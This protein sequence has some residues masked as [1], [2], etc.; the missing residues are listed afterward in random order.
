MRVWEQSAAGEALGELE[1]SP[2][3]QREALDTLNFICER[4]CY[5]VVGCGPCIL[6]RGARH[7]R[8]RC[9]ELLYSAGKDCCQDMVHCKNVRPS[10]YRTL[11]IISRVRPALY[12][13]TVLQSGSLDAL[14]I[15]LERAIGEGRANGVRARSH[16]RT[17]RIDEVAEVADSVRK[18]DASD[19]TRAIC[20]ANLNA[21]G[22]LRLIDFE[23]RVH[24]L[25]LAS[26]CRSTGA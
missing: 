1:D 10:L 24:A 16:A 25:W 11:Q 3:P 21:R 18:I 5:S 7:T 12:H 23:T 22:R 20:E 19:D 9:C 17:A 6:D 2:T 15:V 4:I 13:H 14:R 8:T 26:R